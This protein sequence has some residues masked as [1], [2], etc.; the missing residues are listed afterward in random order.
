[1]LGAPGPY[2]SG[3]LAFFVRTGGFFD[4][5]I[6]G[7][8]PTHHGKEST[9]FILRLTW[10]AVG[11]VTVLELFIFPTSPFPTLGECWVT[12]TSQGILEP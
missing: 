10:V 3:L 11:C 4:S 5:Q 8:E 2:N 1:M 12:V 9:G 7:K 6:T